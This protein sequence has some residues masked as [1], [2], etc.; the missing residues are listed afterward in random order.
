[1]TSNLKAQLVEASKAYYENT[2]PVE[3][4]QA[5]A[6]LKDLHLEQ[7]AREK[8][9]IAINREFENSNHRFLRT[10]GIARRLEAL[11]KRA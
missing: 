6:I 5:E 7:D 3:R 1:M 8:V 10:A 11:A 9:N 4:H 2:E